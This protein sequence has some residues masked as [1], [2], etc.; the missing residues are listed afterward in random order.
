MPEARMDAALLLGHLLG[1]DRGYMISHSEDSVPRELVDQYRQAVDR[2]AK[3]EPLQY[4]T[5]HQEFF[6]LDFEVSPAALIPRPET[7]L[8]VETAIDL[9]EGRDQP[10]ICDVGTGTGCIAIT[11]LVHLPKAK[12]LAIDIS[13]DALELA[14]RNASKHGVIDRI[15]FLLSDCFE[16]VAEPDQF[17]LIASN[18]PYVAED[19]VSGLQREVRDFEPLVALTPGGDGLAVIKR[20][21]SEA[22]QRVR[23][24]GYLLLEI[25]FDQRERVLRLIDEESWKVLDVHKDLQGIPRTVV[26]EKI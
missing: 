1:R 26:L 20:L 23:T 22:Q 14:R 8:L 10:F 3:G 24:G 5:G 2:R 13:K 18:P 17:D 15:T 16:A 7:E 25:G 19:A 21:I 4:I 11:L 12:G 6:G 9:M